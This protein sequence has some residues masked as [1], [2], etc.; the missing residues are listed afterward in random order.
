MD[1]YFDIYFIVNK[2][3]NKHPV[4]GNLWQHDAH[5]TTLQNAP[6]SEKWDENLL[7]LTSLLVFQSWRFNY[8]NLKDWLVL[9][10]L[11]FLVSKVDLFA[12]WLDGQA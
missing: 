4:S 10:V 2:L 1:Q 6:Q 12:P 11:I 3:L 7:N 9:P 8:D 5:M